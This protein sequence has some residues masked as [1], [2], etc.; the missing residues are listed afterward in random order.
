VLQAGRLRFRGA[1]A[2]L[3]RMATGK[4]WNAVLS[5]EMLQQ[6]AGNSTVVRSVRA[7]NDWRVRLLAEAP[8]QADSRPATPTIEDGY[9]YLMRREIA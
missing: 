2:A 4:A 6:A 7:G 8:P 1:P 9:M 5:R 3:A